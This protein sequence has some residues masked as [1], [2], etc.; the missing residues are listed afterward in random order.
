[1]NTKDKESKGLLAEDT[2]S[3]WCDTRSWSPQGF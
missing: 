1:M 2:Q 3:V